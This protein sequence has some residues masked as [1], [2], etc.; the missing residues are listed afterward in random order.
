MTSETIFRVRANTAYER[1]NAFRDANTITTAKG[2]MLS[3]NEA[4]IKMIALFTIGER[5]IDDTQLSCE[6]IPVE[7]CLAWVVF[8]DGAQH[9]RNLCNVGVMR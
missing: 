9:S 6:N 7:D 3:K 4:A 1:Y 2:S 5:V 8:A